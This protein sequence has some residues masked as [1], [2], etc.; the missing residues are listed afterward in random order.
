V[1]LD[2]PFI[3]FRVRGQLAIISPEIFFSTKNVILSLRAG[4]VQE[5]R[6]VEPIPQLPISLNADRPALFRYS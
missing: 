6:H 1:N 3:G 2:Y 5:D 4:K